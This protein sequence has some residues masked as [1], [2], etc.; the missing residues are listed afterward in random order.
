MPKFFCLPEA[1]IVLNLDDHDGSLPNSLKSYVY[2]YKFFF[3]DQILSILRAAPIKASVPLVWCMRVCVSCRI[4]SVTRGAIRGFHQLI[5]HAPRWTSV[6]T[7]VDVNKQR[8]DGHKSRS[9][10]PFVQPASTHSNRWKFRRSLDSFLTCDDRIKAIGERKDSC[11]RFLA[12]NF[13]AG[14]YFVIKLS[15]SGKMSA[16]DQICWACVGLCLTDGC[17]KVLILI[18]IVA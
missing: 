16:S 8:A 15:S 11:C 4:P 6:S 13:H 7:N 5:A 18:T 14:F 17:I 3:C 10:R 9:G 12:Q 2:I 1:Y